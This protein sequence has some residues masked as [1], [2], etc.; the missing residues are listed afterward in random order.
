MKRSIVIFSILA[1]TLIFLGFCGL[2]SAI[3][4]PS[5][6]HPKQHVVE[7]FPDKPMNIIVPTSMGGSLDFLAR[8]LVIQSPQYLGQ[9][10]IV[11]NIS[12][13]VKGWDKLIESQLD[14]YTLA[15]VAPGVIIQPLLHETKYNYLTDIDPIA[16]VTSPPM[17]LSTLTD[18]R[19]ENIDE[20][21][22]FARAN[23]HK[24]K[25]G[26]AGLGAIRHITGAMFAKEANIEIDFVPF[27]GG[28]EEVAAL[29]GKHIQCII[30][31]PSEVREFVK[32][33]SVKVLAVTSEKRLMDSDFRNV[34]T[35]REQG[36]D[37]VMEQWI[38]IGVPKGVSKN[39]KNKLVNSFKRIAND[40]EFEKS[41]NNSGITVTY[42]APDSFAEKWLK[43]NERFKKI[44]KDTGID[45]VNLQ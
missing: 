22:K 15:L 39:V 10:L 24:I 27:N 43:E 20:L 32:Y 7:E 12:G 4:I 19:W 13:S 31:D 25:V 33:G 18:Q 34:P 16:Q 8:T 5:M 2:G 6:N 1:F 41:I 14:G 17:M 26:I 3:A 36:L 37:V 29:L 35:F 38:G 44:L 45:S 42:L 28:T 21:I 23:P 40:P 30:T 9:P 11:T